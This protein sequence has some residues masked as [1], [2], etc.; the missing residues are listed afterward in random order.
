MKSCL[1][2]FALLLALATAVAQTPPAGL[3][4]E[5][6]TLATAGDNDAALAAL[7]KAAAAGFRGLQQ[8]RG[9]NEFE[10]LREDPRFAKVLARVRNNVFPC[11]EGRHYG[12]FDFWAGQWDVF[13]GDGQ[14]AG[15]NS[16]TVRENGCVLEELW[17]GSSG[18]TGRSLNY[19]DASK[20]KWRQHWVS[21]TGLIIDI[22]GGLIDGS[23]VM[24]GRVFYPGTGQE[25][26]FR[27][28]WT[29]LEDGRVRQFFEQHDAAKDT[30]NPWFEGFYVRTGGAGD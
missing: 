22:E 9:A 18:I 21:A 28:T 15:S 2:A 10:A 3:F 16:I 26:G 25:A 12:D 1:I 13:T 8:I 29:P 11:E 6:K 30:W 24:A 14:K 20:D 17:T 23:M 5:A 27:G 19:Y 4:G 7:E